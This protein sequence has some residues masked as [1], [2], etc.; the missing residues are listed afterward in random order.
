[1]K[2]FS[3]ELLDDIVRGITAD[4]R[5]WVDTML[6]EEHGLQLDGPDPLRA[7][8]TTFI[9]FLVVG[10]FPMLPFLIGALPPAYTFTVSAVAAGGAFFAVGVAKGRMLKR[11]ALVAGL[12][13][14]LTGGAAAGLAYL[15]G[16]WLRMSFGVS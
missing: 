14:L 16:H 5:L 2:G 13:T 11:P 12:E 9:A 6:T 1:M 3:G 10:M 8:V 15:I 4:D 7:A